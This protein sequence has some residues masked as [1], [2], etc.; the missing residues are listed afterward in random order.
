M[1]EWGAKLLNESKPDLTKH[2]ALKTPTIAK[3]VRGK[4]YYLTFS[5]AGKI[6]FQGAI[7][8]KK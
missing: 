1:Y 3:L 7:K 6:K 4:E 5:S 8:S 2:E